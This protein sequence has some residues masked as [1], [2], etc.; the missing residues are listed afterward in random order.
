MAQVIPTADAGPGATRRS[1]KELRDT[2]YKSRCTLVMGSGLT[3]QVGTSKV[4]HRVS[5]IPFCA[6]V[7]T[8]N[9]PFIE[10]ACLSTR[11][12]SFK[13][14]FAHQECDRSLPGL[15]TE[16]SLLFT[17]F[18]QDNENLE[19][20]SRF[21][22]KLKLLKNENKHW[23]F[24]SQERLLMMRSELLWKYPG[25][26]I[27]SYKPDQ[28]LSGLLRLFDRLM[29]PVSSSPISKTLTERGSATEELYRSLPLN[30]QT[31]IPSKVI[32]PIEQRLANVQIE[33]ETSIEGY[34]SYEPGAKKFKQELEKQ[35]LG[36]KFR[37]LK[38]T[39]QDGEVCAGM[40]WKKEITNRLKKAQV[41]LLLIN[42]DYLVSFISN[43]IETATAL[44]RHSSKEACVIP[45]IIGSCAWKDH[46]FKKLQCLPRD[47]KPIDLLPRPRRAKVFLE[48]AREIEQSIS[49]L[50]L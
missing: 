19:E 47:E 20:L 48:I 45:I 21:L 8:G 36:I 11:N 32:K 40:E 17:G 14:L 35:L 13:N 43:R 38:I 34:F 28:T 49:K 33:Q 27:I 18:D 1:L 26:H 25:I 39:W 9:N 12:Y 10:S 2:I 16:S 50:K 42:A 46:E 41:I 5:R 3:N 22:N 4:Y 37:G 7:T 23:I 6:Y 30:L 44:R 31:K 15:F 24:I 29:K